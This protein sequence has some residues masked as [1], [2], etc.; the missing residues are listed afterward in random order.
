MYNIIFIIMYHPFHSLSLC[1]D[2]TQY[3]VGIISG[4]G[5]CLAEVAFASTQPNE[6]T[7]SL[8]SRTQTSQ[9]FPTS[10]KHVPLPAPLRIISALKLKSIV[11]SVTMNCSFSHL[12]PGYLLPCVLHSFPQANFAKN[13]ITSHHTQQKAPVILTLS[14]HSYRNQPFFILPAVSALDDYR[15]THLHLSS[16]LI[17]CHGS[18]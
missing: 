17:P 18:E 11:H 7:G 13:P 1:G 5:Q 6:S 14:Q 8:K 15:S 2:Q 16:G 10:N 3:A 4:C 9:T 12:R